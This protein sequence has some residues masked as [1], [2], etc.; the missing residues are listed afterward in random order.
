MSLS[1]SLLCLKFYVTIPTSRVLNPA[2]QVSKE[3][4]GLALLE[5]TPNCAK[6]QFIQVKYLGR[7]CVCLLAAAVACACKSS[8]LVQLS[9][10]RMPYQRKTSCDIERIVDTQIEWNDVA[11]ACVKSSSKAEMICT[12]RVE[13]WWDHWL[14]CQTHGTKLEFA[15]IHDVQWSW[16]W[17]EPESSTVARADWQNAVL[18]VSQKDS[19]HETERNEARNECL[20]S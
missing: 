8:S 20:E 14:H 17:N 19:Y 18:E 10:H 5:P 16:L 6:A 11:C 7:V 9:R 1:V 12:W 13:A 4:T 2:G 15:E 3:F